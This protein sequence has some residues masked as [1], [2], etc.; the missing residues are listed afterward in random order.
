MVVGDLHGDM[1]TLIAMLKHHGLPPKTNYLFLGDYVDRGPNGVETFLLPL[2]LMTRFPGHVFCLRGNHESIMMS[3]CYGFLEECRHRCGPDA[4]FFLIVNAS[5]LCFNPPAVM[6]RQFP[7]GGADLV[8]LWAWAHAP[9]LMF[10]DGV[11]D[12]ACYPACR[13]CGVP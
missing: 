9:S 4:K 3:R 8:T 11:C 6:T 10:V 1:Y 2:L 12:S 5:V 7:F 13:L